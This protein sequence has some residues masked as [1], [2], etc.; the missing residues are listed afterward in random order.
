MTEREIV[1]AD[2]IILGQVRVVITLAVP[3][4][5]AGDLA[6]QCQARFNRVFNR[7]LVRDRQS[8]GEP[9]N[10][11]IHVR[12][13]FGRHTVGC[14]SEHLGARRQLDVDFQSHDDLVGL[15]DSSS[16]RFW[17]GRSIVGNVGY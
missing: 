9:Q 7:L 13:R 4:G 11:F 10:L 17:H 2:L 8:A 14:A 1:L 6:V 15:A 5:P 16:R 3:F 12:I